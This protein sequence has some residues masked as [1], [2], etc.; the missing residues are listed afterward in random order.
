MNTL[1]FLLAAQDQAAHLFR[2]IEE[3][4]L[5]TPGISEREL[6]TAIFDLAFELFG[7]KKY[8]HKRIV[9]SGA[10]TLLPYDENPSDLILQTDDILFIDFGPIFD[11]WEADYGRTYVIGDDPYK[12]KLAQNVESAW[13]QAAQYVQNNPGITGAQVYNYCTQLAV[14]YGWE[15]GG[16]IAGHLIGEFPHEKLDKEDKRNY[17]HP[18]NHVALNEPDKSG[19]SRYWIIEIHFV[20]REQQIGGFFEQLLEL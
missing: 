6:N 11:Q 9:R 1:R 15:F 8:W 16:T 7:I 20:D 18:E 2:Q 3:R 14:D 10:N 12:H 13:Y 19:Q 5:M 17:I 4:G